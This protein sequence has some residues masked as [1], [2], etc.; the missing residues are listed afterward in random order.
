M[1]CFHAFKSKKT[2]KFYTCL[3]LSFDTCK[4]FCRLEAVFILFVSKET[5]TLLSKHWWHQPE[6]WR[7]HR[8]PNPRARRPAPEGHVTPGFSVSRAPTSQRALSVDRVL[9]VSMEM[10]ARAKLQVSHYFK[11]KLETVA[12]KNKNGDDLVCS[13]VWN[14]TEGFIKNIFGKSTSKFETHL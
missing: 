7:F 2:Q 9:Q 6:Y 12:C 3:I 5:K 4:F 11:K 8:G 1:V 14:W 13:G 10:D